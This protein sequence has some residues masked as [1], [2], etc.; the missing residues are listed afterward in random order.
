MKKKVEI[1]FNKSVR[2]RKESGFCP[3]KDLMATTLDKW[4]LLALYNLGYFKVLRFNELKKNIIGISSRMLSVTLK[5]LEKNGTVRRSV[6]AEV[7]PRVDY[8]LTEF[9]SEFTEKVLD[10]NDWFFE[11][12]KLKK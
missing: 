11:K 12:T 10:L 6:F 4:S 5:K 1:Y 8:E 9:G 3:T 2:Y 7:P